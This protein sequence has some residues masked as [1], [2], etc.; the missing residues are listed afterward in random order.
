MLFISKN[1]GIKKKHNLCWDV[2]YYVCLRS[3]FYEIHALGLIRA[4]N[5]SLYFL[6]VF[7]TFSSLFRGISLSLV[8]FPLIHRKGNFCYCLL[9]DAAQNDS[10]PASVSLVL[11]LCGFSMDFTLFWLSLH[12]VR[13]SRWLPYPTFPENDAGRRRGITVM[14]YPL[15]VPQVSTLH[16]MWSGKGTSDLCDLWPSFLN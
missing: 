6:Y 7:I 5:C 14:Y 13:V 2:L 11:A 16:F 1:C 12:K 3:M 4:K 9:R 15:F 8:S 10:T